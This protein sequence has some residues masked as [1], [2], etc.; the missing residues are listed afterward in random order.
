VIGRARRLY[1]TL[2]I[3]FS[4]MVAPRVWPMLGN[5][6]FSLRTSNRAFDFFGESVCQAGEG[7]ELLRG[8]EKNRIHHGLN[9]GC[10]L[11]G[12]DTVGG[13]KPA[14]R[15]APKTAQAAVVARSA[16][17]TPGATP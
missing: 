6:N 12:G 3:C 5:C 17:S 14:A 2:P 13:L 8:A 15:A 7:F 16:A 9:S 11:L 10:H 1:R 4:S